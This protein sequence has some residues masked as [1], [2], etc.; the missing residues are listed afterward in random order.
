MRAITAEGAPASPPPDPSKAFAELAAQYQAIAA[1]FDPSKPPPTE[2]VVALTFIRVQMLD[3][4]FDM[5]AIKLGAARDANAP[6]IVV[7]GR[8]H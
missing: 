1:T 3:L 4:K 6:R 7:P 2:G 5:L 8:G